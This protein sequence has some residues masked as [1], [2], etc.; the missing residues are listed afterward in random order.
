MHCQFVRVSV[1]FLAVGFLQLAETQPA[2]A[3]PTAYTAKLLYSVGNDKSITVNTGGFAS[4]NNGS[5]SFQGAIYDANG[6]VT[7]I[8]SN[9]VPAGS[10][11]RFFATDGHLATGAIDLA[12][13]TTD[14]A[15]VWDI[16][17]NQS[18]NL[19]PAG[20]TLS[21]ALSFSGS[22]IAGVARF[23]ETFQGE[24]RPVYHAI[25]W[26]GA[27]H[28]MSDLTPSLVPGSK[29]APPQGAVNATDGVHQVGSVNEFGAYWSGTTASFQELGFSNLPDIMDATAVALHGNQIV[30]YGTATNEADHPLLWNGVSDVATDLLPAG[31]KSGS[32]S[33]T[34]GTQQVG[35]IAIDANNDLNAVVWSGTSDSMLNL[36]QYLPANL[37]YS[38]AENIDANGNIFG[39]GTDNADNITIVEWSPVPE[40]G[41]V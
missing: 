7:A 20:S 17:N 31:V 12:G 37:L 29:V 30:G 15:F 14:Q 41:V 18:F 11:S 19:N 33:D 22:Q 10:G 9:L 39:I 8:P 28:T 36:E 16:D 24:T 13:T 23:N 38:A 40:P 1:V 5:T 34:N 6:N 32:V 21:R 27:N 3:G 2:H 4:G 25:V 26:N 35:S